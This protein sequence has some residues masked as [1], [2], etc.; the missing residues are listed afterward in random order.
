MRT[1]EREQRKIKL[2]TLIKVI[3]YDVDNLH[4]LAHTFLCMASRH[5]ESN[6][7][8]S[9]ASPS[10]ITWNGRMRNYRFWFSLV[11]GTCDSDYN[12]S[13]DDS[14]LTHVLGECES[15]NGREKVHFGGA[16]VSGTQMPGLR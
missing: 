15:D 3:L 5:S 14:S 7:G 12:E 16:F 2:Q 4:T 9:A 1:P 11:V 13:G 10:L 6:N 8:S